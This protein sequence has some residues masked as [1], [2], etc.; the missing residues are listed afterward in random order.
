MAE[1]DEPSD[2]F[3]AVQAAIGFGGPG[4]GEDP[5]LG[6]DAASRQVLVLP[7]DAAAAFVRG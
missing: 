6:F 2:F 3:T 1:N 5:V 4:Y 7:E